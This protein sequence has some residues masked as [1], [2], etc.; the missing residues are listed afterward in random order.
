MTCYDDFIRKNTHNTLTVE[1]SKRFKFVFFIDILTSSCSNELP[2]VLR[3]NHDHSQIYDI[4]VHS[5]AAAAVVEIVIVVDKLPLINLNERRTFH[6]W[7][8]APADTHQF[9]GNQT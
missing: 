6:T 8:H 5:N 7:I 9:N 4:H 1:K 2:L 3:K